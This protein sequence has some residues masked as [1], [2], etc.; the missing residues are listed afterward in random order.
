MGCIVNITF[1]TLF[2]FPP[3]IDPNLKDV[4]Y[5]VGVAYG[6]EED[7]NYMWEWYNTTDDPY[8]KRLCLRAL[9]ASR[10]PWILSRYGNFSC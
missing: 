8:E 5:Q 1:T 3:S 2:C 7:W 10:E 9:A 6:S 4:V